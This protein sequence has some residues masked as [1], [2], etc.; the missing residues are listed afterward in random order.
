MPDGRTWRAYA[1]RDH[2]GWTATGSRHYVERF[3]EAVPVLIVEDPGGPYLGF[4]R[5]G[6]DTRPDLLASD[7]LFAAW[8]A[9]GAWMRVRVEVRDD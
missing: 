8:G 9:W 7:E 4:Q 2:R 5:H 3:G 6:D 1:A